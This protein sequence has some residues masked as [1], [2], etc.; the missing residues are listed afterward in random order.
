LEEGQ[1]Q[2]RDSMDRILEWN[3]DKVILAHGEN[4]ENSHAKDLVRQAWKGILA[5]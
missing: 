2:A 1:D 4:I 5:A 3:F